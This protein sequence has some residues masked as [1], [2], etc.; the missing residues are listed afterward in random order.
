VVSQATLFD[1]RYPSDRKYVENVI[2]EDRRVLFV[3]INLPGGSN[4]DQDVWYGA[5]TET[6]AQTQERAE[7][8]AADLRWLDYAFTAARLTHAKGLVIIAQADMW[9]PEKGAAHQTGY[10]PFVSSV[11]SNTLAYGG[12]VLMLNGDSHAYLSHNPLSAADSL[13]Y[14]HSGYDVPNF[15]RVVVHGSTLPLQYLRLTVDPRSDAPKG[16]N[17]FGPFS[18]SEVVE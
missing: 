6:A 9:D 11:A 4:N 18:W 10:E 12:P 16:P 13:N 8:R 3:V 17:A 15:H 5:P 2:W 1:P 7:R 14:M